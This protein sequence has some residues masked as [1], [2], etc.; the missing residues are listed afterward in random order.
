MLLNNGET[1]KDCSLQS[2]DAKSFMQDAAEKLGVSQSTV[3]WKVQTAKNITQED[4][5][6]ILGNGI[7]LSQQDALKLSCMETE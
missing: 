3:S 4:K 5:E 2:L 1:S 7:D 6:I